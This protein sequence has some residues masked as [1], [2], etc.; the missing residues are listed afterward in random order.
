MIG[1]G[2]TDQFQWMV[3]EQDGYFT[4]AQAAHSGYSA[5]AIATRVDDGVWDRVESDLLRIGGWP[6]NELEE[7]AKWCAWLGTGA[8]I[9]H[10]SATELHC[11]GN[12]HPQF[13]HVRVSGTA[14]AHDR[15]LAVHRGRLDGRDIEYTG[16][17]RITTPICTTLDLAAGG[18]SQFTLDE[19]VGDGLVLG[20]LDADELFARALESGA[21]VAERIELALS[22]R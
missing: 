6:H 13:V 1:D 20:R 17:F 11:L 16:S 21:R 14:R 9:S 5:M 7:Y 15:R 22:S 19:V 4:T 8:V 10:Q 18:I 12:L 2:R 3:S